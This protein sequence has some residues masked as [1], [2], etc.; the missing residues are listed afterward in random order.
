MLLKFAIVALAAGRLYVRGAADTAAV[1]AVE[2][3]KHKLAEA[4]AKGKVPANAL[5]LI[6]E[7][8]VE[9]DVGKLQQDLDAL[10]EKLG[11][12]DADLVHDNQE[13]NAPVHE[14]SEAPAEAPEP[15]SDQ[16]LIH[17]TPAADR[18]EENA[19][20]S[21]AGEPRV[22]ERRG[23]RPTGTRSTR[24]ATTQP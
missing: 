14:A 2:V 23:T 8:P 3:L 15:G 19:N 10:T 4:A 16:E 18:T 22:V 1:D 11:E 9:A 17:H 12:Q 5:A 13:D 20:S 24:L 6:S 7:S 21:P